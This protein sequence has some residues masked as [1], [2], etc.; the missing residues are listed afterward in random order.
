MANM[1]HGSQAAWSR[2]GLGGLNSGIS[3]GGPPLTVLHGYLFL[4][5][6]L[7]LCSYPALSDDGLA[8]FSNSTFLN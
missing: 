2:P 8:F 3:V 6:R 5:N 7:K 4:K 1:L